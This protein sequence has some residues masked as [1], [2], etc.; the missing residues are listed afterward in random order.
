MDWVAIGL[1]R[2]LR[3]RMAMPACIENVD[4]AIWRAASGDVHA[5]GDRCPHRGMRLSQGFVRGETLSCIYHGWQYGKDGGCKYIPAHPRLDP[6]KS[7]CATTYTCKE[8]GGLI[9]VAPNNTHSEPPSLPNVIPVRSLPI[10]ASLQDVAAY[11]GE[12]NKDI[13]KVADNI[14]V[15][16]PTHPTNCMVHVLTKKEPKAASRWIE[17]QRKQIEM[18][19]A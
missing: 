16:Q 11:F 1:S 8:A 3:Y 5:W 19:P 7:I 14:F 10:N 15:L 4:L 12:P 17:A 13:I 18:F 9:W 6:P 2:D